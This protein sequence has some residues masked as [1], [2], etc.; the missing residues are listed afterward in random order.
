MARHLD[1]ASPFLLLVSCSMRDIESAGGYC[2]V[3]SRTMVDFRRVWIVSRCLERDRLDILRGFARISGFAC[4]RA[5]S[6]SFNLIL[7]YLGLGF[8]AYV[9]L[10]THVLIWNSTGAVSQSHCV[11]QGNMYRPCAGAFLPSG[12]RLRPFKIRWQFKGSMNL[13]YRNLSIGAK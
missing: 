4:S 3:L 2:R 6:G 12:A 5:I 8:E 13:V 7:G 11:Y 10:V 1:G 9:S